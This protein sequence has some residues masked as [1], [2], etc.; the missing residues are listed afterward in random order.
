MSLSRRDL[1]KF[2]TASA[3]CYVGG[4]SP[5]ALSG[6]AAP[7]EQPSAVTFPQG[8]ASADPQPDAI[9]IWTRAES[10]AGSVDL[11]AQ[12]SRDP[13][14]ADIISEQPAIAAPD[15]DYT[16]RVLLTDL[17]PDSTYYYRFVVPGSVTSRT[18]RARTAP[19]LDTNRPLNIAVFSC[20][21]Y[22]QGFFTAYRHMILDD[23]AAPSAR[24]I[25]FVMHVGDF[26]YETIRGAET[27]GA[28]DLN[29]QQIMLYNPDGS[30]RRC[31]PLPSGGAKGGRGWIVPAGL[32]DYR[33]L[34]KHY[35]TDPDLQ[36]A[37]ALYPFVQTWDDHELL[38]DYWQS[39][40]KDKS[41]AELKVAANQ[42]WYEYIPEI[43]RASCRERV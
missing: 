13:H 5:F 6:C 10:P 22:E 11:V 20:Q 30:R 40:Y 4:A 7:G 38:N 32:D 29:N 21:D 39:Y 15:Q 25:D 8:V 1:L 34:Y 33:A 12:L 9:I 27:I 14:F 3:G 18:G 26:I 16:V 37:R 36:D 28:V 42:A 23:E 31:G 43:G 17:E 35:L 41:V 24:K 19:A 2:F